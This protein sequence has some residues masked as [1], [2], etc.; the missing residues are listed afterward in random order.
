MFPPSLF[1]TGPLSS[2]TSQLPSLV[3]THIPLGSPRVSA[4]SVLGWIAKDPAFSPKAI[5][6]PV[7]EGES[8]L[9]VDRVVRVAGE[10]LLKLAERW[11]ASLTSEAGSPELL[12]ARFEEVAWM[13][14]V[15]Y[16]VGGWAG[17][18]QGEDPKGAFNSDFFL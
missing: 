5:G 1:E 11:C 10:K 4:F 3:I 13:N 15:I 6:V 17:R 9:T 8:E 7:P 12:S 14:T 18:N 2:L 16:A